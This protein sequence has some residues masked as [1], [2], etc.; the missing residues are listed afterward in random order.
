ME[1]AGS[2]N[3]LYCDSDSLYVTD[4]GLSNLHH[5]LHPDKLGYWKVEAVGINMEIRGLKDYCFAD[6]EKIKGV[7]KD[8]KLIAPNTYKMSQWQTM[9]ETICNDLHGS[10]AIKPIVK[11]LERHYHKG[12]VTLKGW[13]EP[14]VIEEFT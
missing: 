5:L 1:L 2:R 9:H 10:V 8:A 3:W 14:I 7:S 6:R 11:V 13:V 12:I 4:V